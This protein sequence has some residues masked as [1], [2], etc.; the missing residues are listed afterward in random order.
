[1]KPDCERHL[2]AVQISVMGKSWTTAETLKTK[3]A[4]RI[5]AERLVALAW[6]DM[7]VRLKTRVRCY[8]QKG[9]GK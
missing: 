9:L 1:M 4:A 8:E 2:W 7:G 5:M 6:R 3:A